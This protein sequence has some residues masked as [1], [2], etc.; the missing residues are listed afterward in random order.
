MRP[1]ASIPEQGT[2]ERRLSKP[3]RVPGAEPESTTKR[4]ASR[5]RVIVLVIIS[6]AYVMTRYGNLGREL[7]FEEG[8]FLA[9]GFEFF[10]AGHYHIYW[11]VLDPSLDPFHKPPLC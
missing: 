2:G 4:H 9:P 8:F 1:K 3:R 11:G 7:T 6:L 10:H 5:R